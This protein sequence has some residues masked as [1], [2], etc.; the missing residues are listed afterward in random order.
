MV[1]EPTHDVSRFEKEV[2][3]LSTDG[4]RCAFGSLT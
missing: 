2:G 4:S 3:G 1:S